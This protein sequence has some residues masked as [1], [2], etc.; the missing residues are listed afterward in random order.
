MFWSFARFGENLPWEVLDFA[1]LGTVLSPPL[2]WFIWELGTGVEGIKGQT[3]Y[4]K[5]LGVSAEFQSNWGWGGI[6]KQR[7]W[8]L[9]RN[10]WTLSLLPTL[11]LLNTSVQAAA[12]RELTVFAEYFFSS[13]KP[14]PRVYIHCCLVFTISLEC[15]HLIKQHELAQTETFLHLGL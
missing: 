7:G 5:R 13:H 1:H 3:W 10:L 12:Q 15:W 14:D 6:F 2:P 8:H 9:K 11:T 4:R